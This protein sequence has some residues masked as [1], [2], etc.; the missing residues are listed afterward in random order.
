MSRKGG[1]QMSNNPP[2]NME[3][4]YFI[5][6]LPKHNR[7]V[8]DNEILLPKWLIQRIDSCA[9]WVCR[10]PNTAV[11]NNGA[12]E[13]LPYCESQIRLTVVMIV[14][15][16]GNGRA[17]VHN[18]WSVTILSQ[19]HS[20]LVRMKWDSIC[21]VHSSVFTLSLSFSVQCNHY[22]LSFTNFLIVIDRNRY[23]TV[24]TYL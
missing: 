15:Y 7:T 5:K 17:A 22:C 10:V 19:Q 16:Y 4:D 12:H 9:P 13:S 1:G 23:F 8:F 20:H 14:D 21:F 6:I 18:I 24:H 3:F 11:I 2:H